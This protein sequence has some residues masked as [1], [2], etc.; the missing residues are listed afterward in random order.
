[1]TTVTRAGERC[2]NTS[3][4]FLTQHQQ[5]QQQHQLMVNHNGCVAD[6]GTHRGAGGVGGIS[7]HYR[8]LYARSVLVLYRDAM[9]LMVPLIG[10]P[11]R[12]PD[13]SMRYLCS[14]IS[15]I[16]N[17]RIRHCNRIFY[18]NRV[19]CDLHYTKCQESWYV[20]IF[21]VATLNATAYP[22][23]QLVTLAGRRHR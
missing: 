8:L 18:K 14:N 23:S 9:S 4:S 3:T 6:D 12:F 13:S 1:M 10:I 17:S 19:F 21:H 20:Q 15:A 5:H 16:R 7:R 22:Y 2:Q 11:P